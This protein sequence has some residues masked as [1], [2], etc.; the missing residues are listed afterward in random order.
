MRVIDEVLKCVAFVESQGATGFKPEG[1][2]FLASLPSEVNT[3]WWYVYAITARHVIEAVERK[4]IDQKVY[5]RMNRKDGTLGLVSTDIKDWHYYPDGSSFVDVA[6]LEWS[7]PM[8]ILDCQWF[9]LR[10]TNVASQETIERHAIGIGDEVFLPGLFV[11]HYGKTKN[12][13]IIRVGNIA[14]MPDE[15]VETTAGEMEAYLIEARSIGGLSG[16]PVFVHLGSVRRDHE[17]KMLKYFDTDVYILL[18]LIRGHWDTET[19][20]P[21]E[22]EDNRTTEVV[23][24]GIGIV[25]PARKILETLDQAHFRYR[26]QIADEAERQRRFSGDASV[27]PGG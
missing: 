26:R 16:S 18:G 23:N 20:L 24:M 14:A 2:A 1:T 21:A 25:V 13:P 12:S 6:T 10:G 15:P 8:G 27:N 5:L 11:N 7:V 22:T 3:D 4:G 9:P 17:T 19:V